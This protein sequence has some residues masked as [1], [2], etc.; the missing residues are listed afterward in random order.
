MAQKECKIVD[1]DRKRE[2]AAQTV[3]ML[4][5]VLPDIMASMQ[6]GGDVVIRIAHNFADAYIEPPAPPRPRPIQ[7]HID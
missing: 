7:V 6:C 2:L 3:L 5:K 1:S 4:A